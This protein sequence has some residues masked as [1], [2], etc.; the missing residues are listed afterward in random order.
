M[1]NNTLWLEIERRFGALTLDGNLQDTPAA[2]KVCKDYSFLQLDAVALDEHRVFIDLTKETAE[3]TLQFISHIAELLEKWECEG[4]FVV[5]VKSQTNAVYWPAIV[6]SSKHLY[7]L[8]GSVVLHKE[9]VCV[10]YPVAMVEFR[11]SVKA[12]PLIHTIDVQQ[13]D[14]APL[15]Y[16]RKRVLFARSRNSNT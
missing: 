14:P 1:I 3:T 11:G 2:A 15:E 6:K 9:G 5:L 7:F 8:Q 10:P 12:G 13:L 4:S 16:D